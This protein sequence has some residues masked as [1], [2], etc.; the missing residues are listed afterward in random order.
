MRLAH[1]TLPSPN[2]LQ[3]APKMNISFSF[4]CSKSGLCQNQNDIKK[5]ST[6]LCD[7]KVIQTINVS[8]LLS[9]PLLGIMP[10]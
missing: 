8:G 3:N 9:N 6:P 4:V 2:F 1:P 5:N 7:A 10:I